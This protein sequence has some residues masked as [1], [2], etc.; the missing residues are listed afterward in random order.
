MIKGF[1][2]FSKG[3]VAG[4]KGFTLIELLVVI[5]I[6]GILA[7]IVLASLGSARGKGNDAKIKEQ[8]KSMQSAAE[9]YYATNN[10]YGTAQ[11]S[12]ACSSAVGMFTDSASGMSNLSPASAWPTGASP[13]CAVQTS[14]VAWAASAT[15]SDTTHW[16][17]DSTGASTST[18]GTLTL[19]SA[20]C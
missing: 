12:V 6:S 15:L 14:G 2:T 16:C 4:K 5:A 8:L 7:G 3:H 11:A 19:A 10:S 20:K 13:L 9:I 1:T 17:V 18:A